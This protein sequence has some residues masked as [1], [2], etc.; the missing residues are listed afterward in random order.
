MGRGATKAGGNVWYEARMRAAKW[1]EKLQ[2][3]AGA[4][5]AAGMS[6]DAI[7]N[8]ELELEKCMPVDKAVILADL[9]NAPNLLN[10]YCLNECPI[11]RVRPISDKVQPIEKITVQLLKS[12]R[13]DQLEE[14]KNKLLDIAA[15]GEITEDEVP[16]LAEILEYIEGVAKTVSELRVVGKMAMKNREKNGSHRKDD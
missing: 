10:F 4:A 8:T 6:E 13:V 1:N 5:E 9:Y 3:R 7:K 14:M 12:L 2:S 16:D 11:G 15:D